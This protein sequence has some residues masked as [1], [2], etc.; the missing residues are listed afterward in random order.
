[1]TTSEPWGFY[2]GAHPQLPGVAP[3]WLATARRAEA[4]EAAR[5]SREADERK[6]RAQDRF[7]RWQWQR[8]Q[9]MA[10]RGQPF[11]PNDVRTLAYAPGELADR[12]FAAQDREAARAERKALVEAGV[13]HL[14]PAR[15]VDEMPS[16]SPQSPPPS[17]GSG[18]G[19]AGAATRAHPLG[20]RI[21]AAFDT[22]AHR[23]AT[24]TRTDDGSRDLNEPRYITRS[25]YQYER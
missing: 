21:R 8:M 14:L 19:P 3:G 13:L 7:D 5:E 20:T 2:E 23:A 24:P 22:W 17:S 12:V 11:D 6:A 16:Q 1:M 4:L 15:F 9:E 25:T 10:W 18:L